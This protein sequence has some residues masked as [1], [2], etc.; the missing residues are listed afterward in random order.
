MDMSD[1]RAAKFD[2]R[3][4]QT[5]LAM[6]QT[7]QRGALYEKQLQSQQ[8]AGLRNT[9]QQA[10][11]QSSSPELM[12]ANLL[13]AKVAAMKTTLG[14]DSGTAAVAQIL[15]RYAAGTDPRAALAHAIGAQA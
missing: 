4:F 7:G 3:P 1:L 12:A 2:G 11:S 10:Q 5:G 13:N 6:A 14:E 8:L 9:M 15:S